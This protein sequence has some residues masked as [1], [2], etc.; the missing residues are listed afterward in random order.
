MRGPS[1][2]TVSCGDV[3]GTGRLHRRAGIGAPSH[4]DDH[5]RERPSLVAPW[6]G[7]LLAVAGLS[8]A[9]AME[10]RR[11]AVRIVVPDTPGEL[12]GRDELERPGV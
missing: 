11:R 3:V 5:G 7:L 10:R 8:L 6:L 12:L 9:A 4:G 1:D 2:T